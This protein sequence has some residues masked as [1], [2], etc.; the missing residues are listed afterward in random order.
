VG[1]ASGC[2][3]DEDICVDERSCPSLETARTRSSASSAILTARCLTDSVSAALARAVDKL[4]RHLVKQ[5]RSS[6]CTWTEIGES[7]GMTKQS[8]WERFSVPLDD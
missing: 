8:A 1:S 6:G 2:P 7:L 4:Q 3:D 5:A